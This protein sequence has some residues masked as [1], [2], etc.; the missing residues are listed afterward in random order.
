MNKQYMVIDDVMVVSDDKGGLKQVP[1]TEHSKEMLM[2]ENN[3]EALLKEKDALEKQVSV[4]KKR[5]EL[6][7]K[8]MHISKICLASVLLFGVLLAAWQI[9]S[10]VLVLGVVGVFYAG[11]L[12]FYIIQKHLEQKHL[13]G[14]MQ[15]LENQKQF[16]EQEYISQKSQLVSLQKNEPERKIAPELKNKE[17]TVDLDPEKIAILLQMIKKVSQEKH[18]DNYEVIRREFWEEYNDYVTFDEIVEAY[19]LVRR[20]EKRD[21]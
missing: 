14:S 13:Q 11:P 8:K 2:V 4:L 7:R 21:L 17:V 9:T 16:L 20:K 3:V 12:I 19:Q 18:I 5:S 15:S 10:L 1:Y 6:N